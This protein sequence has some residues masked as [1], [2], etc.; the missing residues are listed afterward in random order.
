M[1]DMNKAYVYIGI[2]VCATLTASG[3]APVDKWAWFRLIVGTMGAGLTAY[4]AY[5][6][7]P[8]ASP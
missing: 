1:Y 7:T 6:S 4:K 3:T 8:P 2:A 5:T